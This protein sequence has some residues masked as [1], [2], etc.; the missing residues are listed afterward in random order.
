MSALSL[1]P[2][3]VRSVI[4]KQGTVWIVGKH[5]FAFR[6]SGAKML[7]SS[8]YM[9]QIADS[10]Q[11]SIREITEDCKLYLCS[12]KPL[13]TLWFVPFAILQRRYYC[14]IV[15]Q[16]RLLFTLESTAIQGAICIYCNKVTLQD[17]HELE[18][19]TS[20][21]FKGILM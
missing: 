13:A 14:S 17:M 2:A 20:I 15:T 10:I 7:R 12:M 16:H 6:V 18:L 8:K 1:L 5:V 21:S 4:S 11:L 9:Q 3:A 19:C